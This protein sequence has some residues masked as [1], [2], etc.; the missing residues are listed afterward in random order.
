MINE[1]EN[2]SYTKASEFQEAF[3]NSP[4]SY[5]HPSA[6]VDTTVKIG[7]GVKI[8]PFCT[9]IGDVTIDDNTSL[10]GYVAI[11]G[12]AQVIGLQ[13]NL[14]TIT[15]GKNCQIR[16]FVSIHASRFTSG[17]T[18]IG[19]D[20]YIMSYSHVG[21]DAVLGNHVTLT[22][23][24]SLGG[25]TVLEDHVRIMANSATHQFCRIGAYTALAPY[26][27]IRQD[28]P[29]YG[30]FSGQP[31]QFAGLNRIGLQRNNIPQQSIEFLR[32]VTRLFYQKNMP[33]SLFEETI[34][35]NNAWSCDTYVQKFMSF[36]TTSMQQGRGISRRTIEQR[37][38]SIENN[39]EK[40]T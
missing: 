21:H 13:K 15:I 6:Q 35:K 32:E 29:P 19:N 1:T 24:S 16:E 5:I 17:T 10:H 30:L 38:A 25:H 14:G 18:I 11:G 36:I 34:N 37:V 12:P 39:E 20:C 2:S 40:S 26:S 9:I 33:L 7:A 28:L 4:D 22:N 3:F 27:G 31:A 8:G 23:N